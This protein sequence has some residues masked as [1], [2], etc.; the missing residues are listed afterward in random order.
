MSGEWIFVYVYTTV[1][2]LWSKI[3]NL[4]ITN[5]RSHF[6]GNMFTRS[7]IRVPCLITSMCSNVPLIAVKDS[8][9]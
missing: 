7:K 5:P 8:H 9:A 3:G 4:K 1:Y 2:P 6:D